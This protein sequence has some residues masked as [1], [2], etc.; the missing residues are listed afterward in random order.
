V[1]TTTKVKKKWSIII[2]M[3][4]WICRQVILAL[5]VYWAC[6]VSPFIPSTIQILTTD[7]AAFNLRKIFN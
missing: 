7:G 4:S 3:I 6:G 5:L 1:G 2:R